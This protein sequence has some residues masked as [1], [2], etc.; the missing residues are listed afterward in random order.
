IWAANAAVTASFL[1]DL[2]WKN[3]K[4]CSCGED[5]KVVLKNSQGE[6]VVWISTVF[7]TTLPEGEEVE[8]GEEGEIEEDVIHQQVC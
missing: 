8:E 4:S 5:V 3:H 2:I 7:R 1:T 6:G